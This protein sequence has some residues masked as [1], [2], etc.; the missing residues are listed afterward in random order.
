MESCI[1]PNSIELILTITCQTSFPT[2]ETLALLKKQYWATQYI[3]MVHYRTYEWKRLH[4][5]MGYKASSLSLT[6]NPPLHR[7]LQLLLTKYFSHHCKKSYLSHTTPFCRPYSTY[8]SYSCPY[9]S[10]RYVCGYV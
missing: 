4:R 8:V 6:L 9:I 1:S 10:N 5:H 3:R 7:N 2:I